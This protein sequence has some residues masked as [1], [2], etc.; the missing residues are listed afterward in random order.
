MALQEVRRQSSLRRAQADLTSVLTSERRLQ[1]LEP[2]YEASAYE[3]I[4]G[5]KLVLATRTMLTCLYVGRCPSY[6]HVLT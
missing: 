3:I 2:G 4:I 6:A 1:L 5:S